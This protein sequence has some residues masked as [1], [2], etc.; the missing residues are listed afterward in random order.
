MCKILLII[1]N[2]FFLL[3]PVFEQ[4][5]SAM[6]DQLVFDGL[7][8]FGFETF[9]AVDD[10]L[11]FDIVATDGENWEIRQDCLYSFGSNSYELLAF[12]IPHFLPHLN[13][14]NRF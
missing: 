6:F 11:T 13:F 3:L 1:Q 9:Q 5:H 8:T 2:Y 10:G 4:R 12:I 14:V 7:K